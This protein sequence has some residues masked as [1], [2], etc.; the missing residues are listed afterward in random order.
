MGRCSPRG[1][2]SLQC[3]SIRTESKSSPNRCSC[4]GSRLLKAQFL[5]YLSRVGATDL[6]CQG[7]PSCQVGTVIGSAGILA[8]PSFC[9]GRGPPVRTD[10]V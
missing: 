4:S 6:L 5:G 1:P 8:S 7:P 10:Q 2:A 3:G 9:S